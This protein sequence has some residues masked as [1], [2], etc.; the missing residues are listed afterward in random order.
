[1]RFVTAIGVTLVVINPAQATVNDYCAAYARD[2]ADH[3]KKPDPQ[4]QHRYDNAE[5]SCLFR[6]TTDAKPTVKTKA[7]VKQAA[8]KKPPV[9]P[10]APVEAAPPPPPVEPAPE[11]AAKVKP[12]L[13]PGSPEWTDYCT[14]KYVSFNAATGTYL[15]KSGKERKCL[16]TAE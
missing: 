8:T 14:K 15:S 12:K 6:F 1:M 3:V 16:V 9:A 7:K 5:A 2:F 10:P 13:T 11:P 4:W